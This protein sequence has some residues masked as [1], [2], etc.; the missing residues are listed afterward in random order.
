MK[1]ILKLISLIV[2]LTMATAL[3]LLPQ[4]ARAG[5]DDHFVNE[6]ACVECIEAADQWKEECE[7]Q[8]EWGPGDPYCSNTH[9]EMVGEC[10]LNYCID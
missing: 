7:A 1:R 8:W 10:Q 9:R 2:V 5:G 4:P 6:Q 3:S